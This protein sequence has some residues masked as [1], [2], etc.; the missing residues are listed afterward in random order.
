MHEKNIERTG[1]ILTATAFCKILQKLSKQLQVQIRLCK[2]HDIHLHFLYKCWLRI[3]PTG[4]M[5]LVHT[6]K[7]HMAIHKK[8]KFSV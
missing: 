5:Q 4:I 8:V 6:L 1:S 2:L 7:L 3:N